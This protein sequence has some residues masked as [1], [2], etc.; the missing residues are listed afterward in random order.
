[1]ERGSPPPDRPDPERPAGP[2]KPPG[3][4]APPPGPPA[5]APGPQAPAPG[6]QAAPPPPPGPP[7]YAPPA[8]TP[9]TPP[10]YGGPV[11]PGGWQQPIARP[12]SG[13]AGQ[14]LASWGSRLGA[15]IIDGLIL[16]IPIVILALVIFGGTVDS[17]SSAG[18][19]IGASI[20]YAVLIAAVV[21]F[22]AP[23]LMMRQG[24]RNGQ[25]LG[26]QVLSIRVV[27]DNGQPMGFG[28]AALR[29]VVLKQLAV[30]IA[31][32]IIPI[33]PWFLNYFWPL[34]DDENRALHD[35]VAST[36]VIRA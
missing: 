4:Q 15:Y 22:Y 9:E 2:G 3:P 12:E 23:L 11:P 31:S 7:G 18:A 27:R 21:L 13:W 20:L 8:P 25:T 28:W 32:S 5:P 26:K 14:P 19:W 1:M 35:M 30:N 16:L 6:P 36:H 10:G 33:I 34:W 17:D 29:E 24:E